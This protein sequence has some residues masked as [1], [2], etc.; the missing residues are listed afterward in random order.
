[1]IRRP[2]I[3]PII[4]DDTI[5]RTTL[6]K[7][8]IQLIEYIPK[9]TIPDPT[10]PPISACEELD[11]IPRMAVIIFQ[12]ILLRIADIIKRLPISGVDI[13]IMEL[14]T[15]PEPTVFATAVPRKIAPSNSNVQPKI[16]AV[17]IFI[18]LDAM[19]VAMTLPP[20]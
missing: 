11:G 20:S 10:I 3:N 5:T 13:V 9:A 7:N 8:A 6:S 18:D 2:V 15:I 12:M 19:M 16:N 4:G 17:L 14:L 1:M